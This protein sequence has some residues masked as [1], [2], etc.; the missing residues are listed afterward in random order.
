MTLTPRLKEILEK[1]AEGKSHKMIASDLALSVFTVNKYVQDL[2]MQLGADTS[3]Q[4][5]AM[6]IRRGIIE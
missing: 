3:S 6:G 5:V 1:L 4:A 2:H